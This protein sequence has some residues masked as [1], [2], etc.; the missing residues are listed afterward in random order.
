V[1]ALT[2]IPGFRLILIP[3][4]AALVFEF[5]VAGAQAAMAVLT[6]SWL[7]LALTGHSPAPWYDGD[8]RQHVVMA[9]YLAALISAAILPL[10]VTLEQKD[11]LTATLTE[12]LEETRAAWGAIIAADARYRLVVD[13][14]TEMVMRVAPDGEILFAS[15]RCESLGRGGSLVG[16]NLFALME[17]ADAHAAQEAIGCAM[18][19][20]LYDLPQHWTYRLHGA[21]GAL[22]AYDVRATLIAPGKK[23]APAEF[24]F[25]LRPA[26]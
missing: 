23:K 8:P 21:D 19:A 1:A 25:V 15:K 10:A 5:G 6:A 24:V 2:P 13:Y 20:D 16:A 17:T 3:L 11:R 12:T 7:S 9:Q 4:L 18:R 26:Q 14:A 22:R